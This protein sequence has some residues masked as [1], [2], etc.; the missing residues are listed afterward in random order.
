MPPSR[1]TGPDGTAQRI[2]SCQPISRL[3]CCRHDR[4][5]LNPVEKHLAIRTRQLAVKPCVRLLHR[6]RAAR[7]PVS[8]QPAAPAHSGRSAQRGTRSRAVWTL[9][10]TAEAVLVASSGVG[11]RLQRAR[12]TRKP[13]AS[14]SL[15]GPPCRWRTTQIVID[16]LDGVEP[17]SPC[18]LDECVLLPLALRMLGQCPR[19]ISPGNLPRLPRTSQNRP[20]TGRGHDRGQATDGE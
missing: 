2:L 10:P 4:P 13:R 20:F 16:D 18:D 3:C 7:S 12:R 11:R 9:A 14:R 6:K 19:P 8:G 5:E 1:W 15:V 17:A